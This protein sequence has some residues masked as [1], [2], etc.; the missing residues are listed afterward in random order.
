MRMIALFL[1]MAMIPV[2][3]PCA[4]YLEQVESEVFEAKEEAKE[5]A[6]RAKACIAQ[7]VRNDEVR[8]TDSAASS[9][10]FPTLAVGSAGHSDGIAGGDVVVHA[11]LEGGKI[12]NP[13][14]QHRVRAEEH[15]VDAQFGLFAR[16]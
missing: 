11:D 16:R 2:A 13:S 5:I 8:I 15:W 4:E 9:G 10:P 12:Q 3:A 6:N 7:H 1:T 14:F